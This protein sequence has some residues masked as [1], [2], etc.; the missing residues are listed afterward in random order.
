MK[1]LLGFVVYNEPNF[2]TLV[3][4]HFKSRICELD[5]LP[6]IESEA[7]KVAFEKTLCSDKLNWFSSATTGCL[8][9]SKLV[10]LA[11]SVLQ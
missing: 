3:G 11:I 5:T 9:P 2:G 6:K 7:D 1:V 4:P 10:L 8:R